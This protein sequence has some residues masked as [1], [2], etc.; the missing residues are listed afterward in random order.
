[1][2]T[3]DN[4]QYTHARRLRRSRVPSLEV[5]RRFRRVCHSNEQSVAFERAYQPAVLIRFSVF[6]K[7]PMHRSIVFG[8]GKNSQFLRLVFGQVL[9][10]VS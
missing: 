4:T 3:T 8:A 6:H 9:Y 10:G 5:F 7:R 2:A 1:M